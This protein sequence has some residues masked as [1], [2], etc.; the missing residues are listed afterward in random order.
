[1]NFLEIALSQYGIKE[2]RGSEDNPQIVR[3]A[4]ETG[5]NFIEDDETPW[6]STF[7]NWCAKE[8]GLPKSGKANARSWLD[9]GTATPFPRP[10]DIVVFWRES[11][12]SHKGHVGIFM[13]F[14]KDNNQVLCLGGN[15]GN[16]VSITKYSVERVLSYRVIEDGQ[17]LSAPDSNPVLKRGGKGIEEV[18][19][20][21]V[22]NLLGYYQDNIDGD[23]GPM[24]EDA[25]KKL[26]GDN[27]L[28]VDGKYG[29]KSQQCITTLL[30]S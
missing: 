14:S 16:A 15:Q 8:A 25:L 20:Q 23:F 22:L 26:Q 1:M 21:L 3:Y 17:K 13:G 29:N 28:K 5:I 7:I 18:K 30:Q 4:Q 12:Q 6:C 9:V 11:P 24:T 19:L 27:Q 2:I 10:G